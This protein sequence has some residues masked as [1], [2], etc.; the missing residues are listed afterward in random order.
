MHES[1]T[2]FISSSGGHSLDGHGLKIFFE[3]IKGA[4]KKI[5]PELI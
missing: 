1:T 5:I 4:L 2:I 3:I